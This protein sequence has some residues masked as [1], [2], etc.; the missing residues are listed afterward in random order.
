MKK[1]DK[2][3]RARFRVKIRSLAIEAEI[4]R[5]EE[6]KATDDHDRGIL[7]AH[8]VGVLRAESRCALLAYAFVRGV[9]YRRVEPGGK[10]PMDVKRIA[11]IVRSLTEREAL[12][13]DVEKWRQAEIKAAV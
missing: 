7:H 9:A 5:H 11:A 6:K 2:L 10:Q 3:S 8:R 1:L 13:H 4:I 12:P